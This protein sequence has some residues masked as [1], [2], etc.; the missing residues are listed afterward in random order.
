MINAVLDEMSRLGRES[1]SAGAA[2]TAAGAQLHDSATEARKM[3]GLLQEE[4]ILTRERLYL[5]AGAFDEGV[6][7]VFQ[8][9]ADSC[10]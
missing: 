3:I 8:A 5:G 1:M 10:C 7:V 4:G 9:F 2:E 6:R